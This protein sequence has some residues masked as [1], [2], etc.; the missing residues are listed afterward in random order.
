MRAAFVRRKD[1]AARSRGPGS[2]AERGR[3]IVEIALREIG[4]EMSDA[5]V[6]VAL[7]AEEVTGR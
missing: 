2:G 5:I 7:E 6:V 3:E 1:R 4:A